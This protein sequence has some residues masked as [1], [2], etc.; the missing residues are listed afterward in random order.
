MAPEVLLVTL[1]GDCDNPAAIALR[2]RFPLLL[3]SQTPGV[4]LLDVSGVTFMDAAGARVLL[5]IGH[6]AL[7]RGHEWGIIT[8]GNRLVRLIFDLLQWS[9]GL[10]LYPDWSSAHSALCRHPD[11]APPRPMD[12]PETESDGLPL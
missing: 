11:Q 8:G 4:L 9:E 3:E 6:L 5:W 10:P 12:G 7:S 2:A 1:T